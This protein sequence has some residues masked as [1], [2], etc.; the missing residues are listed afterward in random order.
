MSACTFARGARIAALALLVTSAP[1]L[2][3]QGFEELLPPAESA[4]PNFGLAVAL[5]GDTAL[6]GSRFATQHG[7]AAGAAYVFT[8]DALGAWSAPVELVPEGGSPGDLFGWSVA[9]EG[10]TAFVG[11]PSDDSETFFPLGMQ[12][13]S[14]Y[15]FDRDAN[16]DWTQRAKLRATQ[17]LTSN[18]FG[19]ALD[20]DDDLLVVG[21]RWSN[22]AGLQIAG[23]AYVFAEVGGAWLA[24]QQLVASDAAEADQFGEAVSVS[25][26]TVAVGSKGHDHS[27]IFNTNHGAAYVY[28]RGA[29]PGSW[30]EQ[31]E[32]RAAVPQLSNNLGRALSLQGDRLVVGAPGNG[33]GEVGSGSALVFERTGDAWTEVATLQPNDGALDDRFGH[34]LE[35]RGEHVVVGAYFRDD[36]ALNAGAAYLVERGPA[37]D[38]SRQAKLL[39]GEAL[40]GDRLGIALAFDGAQILLG[41]SGVDLFGEGDGAAYTLP[42]A[43]IAPWSDRVHALAGSDGPPSLAGLGPLLPDT[44]VELLLT[45]ALPEASVFVVLGAGELGAPFKGGVLVPE[46]AQLVPARVGVDGEL[47]LR[48]RWPAGVPSGASLV[49]QAW[50]ADPGAPLGYAASNALSATVP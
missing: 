46:P 48:G 49:M 36:A 27:P 41:A 15:V 9:L 42:L 7:A 12:A 39:R 31:A 6:I 3:A 18:Q 35:L 33:S 43:W 22:V 11:A 1:A 10:D 23:S 25:G 32:L 17:E 44:P 2:H 8:R 4:G 34:A 30:V 13:G 29:A 21:A 38:W 28:V 26:D 5:D 19:C 14:V 24:E 45:G 40:L 50:I 47:A 16:G 20:V 37:G